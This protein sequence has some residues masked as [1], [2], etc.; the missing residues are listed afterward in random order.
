MRARHT[1]RE[2]S[3]WSLPDGPPHAQDVTQCEE[4]FSLPCFTAAW[5]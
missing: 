4:D 2:D 3:E 1:S 5:V